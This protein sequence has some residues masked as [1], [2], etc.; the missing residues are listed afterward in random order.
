MPCLMPIR[1][2]PWFMFN[3]LIFNACIFLILIDLLE[4]SS[5]TYVFF[6]NLSGSFVN[7]D[8][9]KS[10]V[11]F[12]ILEEDRTRFL[13][14]VGDAGGGQYIINAKHIL[15]ELA[16]S[17]IENIIME[18]YGSKTLR[19]FRVIRQKQQCEES[20]LQSR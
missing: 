9:I 13:D 17:T 15:T 5:Q 10:L 3:A 4:V 2:K 6:K 8:W 18:R 16:A 7:T 12:Q 19:I 20:M 11:L 14:R 1:V